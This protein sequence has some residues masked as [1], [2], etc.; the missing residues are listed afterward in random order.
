VTK[1]TGDIP[2]VKEEALWISKEEHDI[3]NQESNAEK[4]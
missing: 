3:K 2:F 1:E 4:H